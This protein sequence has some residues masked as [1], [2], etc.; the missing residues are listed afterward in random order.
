MDKHP[1]WVERFRASKPQDRYYAKSWK[2]LLDDK[3]YA[4]DAPYPEAT[5]SNPNRFPFMF[6]SESGKPAADYYGRLKVSPAV[7]ELTLEFAEAAGDGAPRGRPPTGAP[8]HRG[9][10]L[11]GPE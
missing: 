8:D 5:T 6:Y 3:A 1:A 7:D 2:P 11:S 4:D 10:R 9:V